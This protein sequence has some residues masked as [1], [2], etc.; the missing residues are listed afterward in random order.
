MTKSHHSIFDDM[1]LVARCLN[2]LMQLAYQYSCNWRYQFSYTKKY[3]VVF[4][5]SSAEHSKNKQ[6][7]NWSLGPDYIDEEEEFVNSGVYKNYCG[8]FSKHVDENSAK[9]RKKAGMLFSANFVRKCVNL[10]IYLKFW[11]QACIPVLLF[12]ANIWPLT[13]THLEKLERCK[14]WFIKR[15]FHLPDY[16]SNKILAIVSGIPSVATIIIRKNYISLTELS[17]CQKYLIL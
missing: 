12:G 2:V 9:T 13:S 5:E 14:R 11:K 7:Q 6:T 3:V 16:K 8:S 4:S 15:L 10:M 17:N 1:T